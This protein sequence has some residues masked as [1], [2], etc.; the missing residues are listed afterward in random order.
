MTASS[1]ALWET[2]STEQKYE[3]A[4]LAAG[5]PASSSEVSD[6]DP[7]MEKASDDEPVPVPTLPLVDDMVRSIYLIEMRNT[8]FSCGEGA[9]LEEGAIKIMLISIAQVILMLALGFVKKA[10]AFFA[11][12]TTYSGDRY[13]LAELVRKVICKGNTLKGPAITFAVVTALDL[14]W[15]AVLV[16]MR[17]GTAVM[18]RGGQSRVLSVQ[19]LVFLLTLLAELC[20]AVLALVSVAAS[21]VDG[22]RRG[23][24]ALRQAWRLMT[25]VRRKE[26]LLLVLLTYL[27]PTVVAPVYRAALVYSRRSMAAGLCVLAGYAFMFGALQL[28]YL[29][30]ATVFYYEAM[31]RK[32]VVPCDQG[33]FYPVSSSAASSSHGVSSSSSGARLLPVKRESSEEPE[34]IEVV[35]VNLREEV[36]RR[37]HDEELDD[38]ILQQAVAANLATKKKDNEWRRIRE[39]QR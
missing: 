14:A 9:K 29:A 17:A 32:E 21:V 19:G 27:L 6:N 37:R 22:E 18:M 31:E 1:S 5:L 28:V 35:A 16:A 23:V 4:G 13:S 11:A 26:G 30:A 15:T 20:F 8:G 7:M 33:R 39:E 25:R 36:E 12:S 2:L 24:R 3:L 34:E 38:L 10:L